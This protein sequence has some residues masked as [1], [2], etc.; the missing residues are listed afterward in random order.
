MASRKNEIAILRMMFSL[1]CAR[2]GL[3]KWWNLDGN[4]ANCRNRNWL[5][6]LL[7]IVYEGIALGFRRLRSKVD[8]NLFSSRKVLRRRKEFTF[9]P[10]AIK[11]HAVHPLR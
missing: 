11:P 10:A 1:V 4:N 7:L 2:M 3:F 5:E 8:E 6:G 9:G